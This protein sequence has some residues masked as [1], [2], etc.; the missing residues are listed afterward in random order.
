LLSLHPLEHTGVEDGSAGYPMVVRLCG[1]DSSSKSCHQTSAGYPSSP[2]LPG[3][4][5]QLQRDFSASP[6]SCAINET[7]RR[8]C[9]HDGHGGAT[10][11]SEYKDYAE[12]GRPEAPDAIVRL[13]AWH[14]ISVSDGRRAAALKLLK[15]QQPALDTSYSR[16]TSRS[17][18]SWLLEC[19]P[20]PCYTS[21]SPTP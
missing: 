20:G 1:L 16:E 5:G 2:Y 12:G 10:S 15:R 8:A 14:L 3:T 9:Q 19:L 4:S 17:L 11:E 7:S 18:R 21:A 13:P 6:A